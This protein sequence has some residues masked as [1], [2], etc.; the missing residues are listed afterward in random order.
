MKTLFSLLI[1]LAITSCESHD[2]KYRISGRVIMPDS[3]PAKL[4]NAVWFTDDINFDDSTLY[5]FNS[6]GSRVNIYPP[7][8][9]DTLR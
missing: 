8:D 6:N 7:F 5:Y 2:Y 4:H 3:T 1:L 9:I